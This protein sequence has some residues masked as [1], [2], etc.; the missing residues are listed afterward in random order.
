MSYDLYASHPCDTKDKI[1][2]VID[3]ETLSVPT[4]IALLAAAL[5]TSL[6]DYVR[7][8]DGRQGR[9]KRLVFAQDPAKTPYAKQE[10]VTEIGRLKDLSL[11][12]PASPD[13]ASLPAHSTFLQLRFTLASPY[14]SRDDE[15]FH[16]NSNPVRKDKVFKVP[17]VAG[18]AWKGNLRWTAVHLLAQRWAQ[19]RNDE[20]LAEGRF[21]L[22]LLF[23]DEKVS[24]E[25]GKGLAQYPHGLSRQ[26]SRLYEERA[27]VHFAAH[28]G[29]LPHH[30]GR[31]RFYPTFFDL[32]GLEVI[33]PHDRRTRAGKKPIYME[34]VPVGTSG[35]FSLLYVPFD[36]VSEPE[37]RADLALVAEAI[38]EMMLT[39]G[40][41]AKKSSGFGEAKDLLSDGWLVTGAGKPVPLTRLSVLEEEVGHVQ[42]S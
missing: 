6:Q 35:T 15:V 16:I 7:T 14:L 17:M 41:S 37:G 3:D 30:A 33:N 38:R 22:A 24:E 32:I 10:I 9:Y 12:R 34:S 40:F 29:A 5:G 21:R 19:D 1:H 20:Q 31:L 11:W 27:R 18:S 13:L 42:W 4:R 23:G 36:S 26:A 39:Y 8:G 2:G 28:D 25:Q